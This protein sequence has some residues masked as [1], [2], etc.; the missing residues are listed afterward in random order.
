[1]FDFVGCHWIHGYIVH[2]FIDHKDKPAIGRVTGYHR[3]ARATADCLFQWITDDGFHL[4]GSETVR[5]NV[6]HI[7]AGLVVPDEIIPRHA[8][9]FD[10]LAYQVIWIQTQAL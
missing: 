9:S 2:L 8:S 4:L 1:M 3:P 10:R 5:R 7:T 6:F